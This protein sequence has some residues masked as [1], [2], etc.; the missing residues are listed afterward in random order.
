MKLL[1]G[2]LR[3]GTAMAVG[4]GVVLLAPIVIPVLASVLK[5]VAK[6]VIKGGMLAY[7]Y[8][9]IAVAETKETFEDIAA[10]ARSEI[11]AG[12]EQAAKA[13]A[14]KASK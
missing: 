11:A 10:E 1:G 9:R 2:E 3:T 4:A 6:A 5:P 13:S 8:A 12:H 14:K 7:E